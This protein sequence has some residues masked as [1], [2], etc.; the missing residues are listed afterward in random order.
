MMYNKLSKIERQLF[1]LKVI[2]LCG[3]D[4]I[5]DALFKYFSEKILTFQTYERNHLTI[6]NEAILEVIH[7]RDEIEQIDQSHNKLDKI[8]P[9][10]ISKIASYLSEA[11]YTSFEQVN[12]NIYIGTH[13]PYSLTTRDTTLK[14]YP[15]VPAAKFQPVTK[16]KT[17]LEYLNENILQYC[18]H[19]SLPNIETLQLHDVYP[20][21]IRLNLLPMNLRSVRHLEINNIGKDN[22]YY[23]RNWESVIRLPP[24]PVETKELAQ[25]L[26]SFPNIC[27]L[28]F[29]GGCK[30]IVNDDDDRKFPS[31]PNLTR[32]NFEVQHHYEYLEYQEGIHAF[33][34]KLFHSNG[35]SIQS[36][37]IHAGHTIFGL[38]PYDLPNLKELR[39]ELNHNDSRDGDTFDREAYNQL[40]KNATDL[41]IVE[42]IGLRKN[43]F[44]L[45]LIMPLISKCNKLKSLKLSMVRGHWFYDARK[46]NKVGFVDALVIALDELKQCVRKDVFRIRLALTNWEEKR[47]VIAELAMATKKIVEI[48]NR[49]NVNHWIFEVGYSRSFGNWR[50]DG[51]ILER[52]ITDLIDHDA[53]FIRRNYCNRSIKLSNKAD[54]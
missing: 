44:V 39:I 15:R 3:A 36:I 13:S 48:M 2:A 51:D 25:F 45:G 22:D 10:L 27:E 14:N 16:L 43:H 24:S 11:D 5:K 37:D 38:M 1:L 7:S 31:L 34:D 33:L 23:D 17:T 18:N 47:N 6:I 41:E 52:R 40:L 42:I 35:S 21:E 54:I 8:S 30:I 4:V 12:R 26:S 32:F 20:D 46:G 19:E 28:S 9:P 53:C 50:V 49:A 29:K